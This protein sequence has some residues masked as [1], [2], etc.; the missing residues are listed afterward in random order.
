MQN[1][2]LN[3]PS[4]S[5]LQATQTA[6]VDEEGDCNCGAQDRPDHNPH[7]DHCNLRKPKTFDPF[8]L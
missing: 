8:N 6:G 2:S 3:Q 1:V 7:A 5:S 4:L